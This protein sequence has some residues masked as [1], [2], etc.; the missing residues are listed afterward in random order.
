[1]ERA[2]ALAPQDELT[3]ADLPERIQLFE[4]QGL[5]RV[6]A[7]ASGV[8]TAGSLFDAERSHVLRV[9]QQL[10]GNKTRAAALLGI[11]RRTL[12]RRLQLYEASS[13]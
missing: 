9:V 2:L 5:D 8:D 6:L 4:P 1:M 11:D 13:S 3:V 10:G 7:V 12:Y